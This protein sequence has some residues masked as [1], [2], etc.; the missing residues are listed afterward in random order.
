MIWIPWSSK[1]AAPRT[2]SPDK[3]P[4]KAP[5]THR[6]L[7]WSRVRQSVE[8]GLPSHQ[9][10]Q[11]ASWL[12][13][14]LKAANPYRVSGSLG[15][16]QLLSSSKPKVSTEERGP[17]TDCPPRTIRPGGAAGSREVPSVGEDLMLTAHDAIP[18]LALI[19]SLIHPI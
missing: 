3:F 6:A 19:F 14:V 5:L 11:T 2:P 10:P 16:L 17:P 8:T 18:P 15:M 1:E 12:E 4:L 9:P 13:K 7:D